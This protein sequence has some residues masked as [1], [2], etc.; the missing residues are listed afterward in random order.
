MIGVQLLGRSRLSVGKGLVYFEAIH[1]PRPGLA[2]EERQYPS[3]CADVD[4]DIPLLHCLSDR[5]SI[6]GNT[7]LVA[8]KKRVVSKACS[9]R[10][11]LNRHG[12]IWSPALSRATSASMAP[13]TAGNRSIPSGQV[14]I[15]IGMFV[16]MHVAI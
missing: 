16:A 1:A 7:R 4:D 8:E 3:A 2:S 6:V 13:H 14:N 11:H 10:A 5:L 12:F 15:L 9:R